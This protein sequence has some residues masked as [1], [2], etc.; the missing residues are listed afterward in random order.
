MLSNR[1]WHLATQC[2]ALLVHLHDLH[3]SADQLLIIDKV[4]ACVG[5]AI[6]GLDD[7]CSCQTCARG[8]TR[9]LKRQM[10]WCHC[11]V[12]SQIVSSILPFSGA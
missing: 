2:L 4:N 5:C 10:D 11:S 7:A 1:V 12:T 8:K 6:S 3:I 9:V